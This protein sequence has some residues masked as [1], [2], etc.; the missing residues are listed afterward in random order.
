[1]SYL[2]EKPVLDL[3]GAG[4]PGTVCAGVPWQ[5]KNYPFSFTEDHFFIFVS[6]KFRDAKIV[7]DLGA[8]YSGSGWSEACC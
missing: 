1:M 2:T 7:F 5:E 8:R 6:K 4:S 3:R